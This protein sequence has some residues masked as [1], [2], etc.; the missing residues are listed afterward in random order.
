MSEESEHKPPPTEAE[1]LMEVAKAIRDL[2]AQAERHKRRRR[3]SP[4]MGALDALGEMNDPDK[5][6]EI[7]R[8]HRE[9]EQSRLYKLIVIFAAVSALASVASVLVAV[10]TA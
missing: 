6:R 1:A 9:Q 5:M 2:P 10:L 7:A 3:N 4:M 8:D